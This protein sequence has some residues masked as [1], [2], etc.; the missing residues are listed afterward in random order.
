MSEIEHVGRVVGELVAYDAP[1]ARNPYFVYHDRF[2]S[3]ESRRSVRTRLA[4][5]ARLISEQD[6]GGLVAPEG[7]PWHLL[8]REH[9]QHIRALIVDQAWAPATREAH[10]TA[11]RGVLREA[12]RLGLMST[13]DYERAADIAPIGGHREPVGQHVPDDAVAAALWGCLDDPEPAGARDAAMIG[14]LYGSGIRRKELATLAVGGY[15]RADRAVTVIGKGDKQ[16]TVP[17]PDDVARLIEAWLTVRGARRPGALFGRIRGSKPRRP[18][19]R[20]RR[21]RVERETRTWLALT[22]DGGV[23][24]LSPGAVGLIVGDRFTAAGVVRPTAHDFRRTYIGNMLDA[25]VDLATAQELVG[26]ANPATTARY[27][28]RGARARRAAAD[29]LSIPVPS[30]L[31]KTAG[32][33]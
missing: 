9:T 14:L 21:D 20:R 29:R 4:N 24:H 15:D 22:E 25:G 6:D 18:G 8:R 26:H 16:R 13:D 28:R 10:R 19:A 7:V 12:W 30:P 2:A 27:D 1:R 33:S 5:V 3:P 32:P 17:V 23:P 31:R 11:V